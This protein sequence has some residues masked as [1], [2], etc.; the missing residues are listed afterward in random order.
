MIKNLNVDQKTKVAFY[1]YQ[2]YK[3][4]TFIY[5]MVEIPTIGFNC[6][7]KCEKSI[8]D[9]IHAVERELYN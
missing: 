7:L 2:N 4:N 6:L 9:L 3:V 1:E 5:G 8:D